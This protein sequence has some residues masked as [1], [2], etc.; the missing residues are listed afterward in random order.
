M[1]LASWIGEAIQQ[2][3]FTSEY[4]I[5]RPESF[6]GLALP[7]RAV[8][9]SAVAWLYAR[10]TIAVDRTGRWG[11][12]SLIGFLLIVYAANLFGAPPPS[13]EAIA[14]VG[15]L[16]WLLILWGYWIDN[17]RRVSIH[18]TRKTHDER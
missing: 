4:L 1:L 12:W 15:Q 3:L 16:Q 7:R 8:S 2:F 11:F 5:N 13:A 17:H 9:R 6:P 14:W 18:A 10:A